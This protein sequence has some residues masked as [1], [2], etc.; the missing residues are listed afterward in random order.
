MAYIRRETSKGEPSTST[1]CDDAQYAAQYTRDFV[2]RWDELIDWDKRAAAEGGFFVDLLSKA[3]ADRVID[4]S[5]G[6]GFHAVQLHKAGFTVLACDGSPTMV[7]RARINVKSRQLE[8]PVLQRDWLELDSGALGT[9]DAVLC[10]GSSLCHVF[11]RHERQRVLRRFR[12]LLK[13]GGVLLVDQR[14]FRA[15]RA[16]RYKSSGRYYYC[17]RNVEVSLGEVSDELCE[18]IY[19]FRDGATYGLRVYPIL[20]EE[21]KAEISH[22]GFFWPRSFGDFK[23]IYDPLD[24]D[25]IIH[26]AFAK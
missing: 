11:D 17:G 1:R 7:E 3:G 24:C 2:S 13:P 20:P 6:S 8:I 5:T 4:V 18:F 12:Q 15:I 26:M 21:L 9:F 22:A 16:G 19:S 25:F 23:H 14:N 10:L